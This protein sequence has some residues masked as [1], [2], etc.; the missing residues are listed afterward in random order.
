MLTKCRIFRIMTL[1]QWPTK[2]LPYEILP[3]DPVQNIKKF[4]F[5]IERTKLV[6]K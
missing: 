4:F 1:I 2:G 3:T 5:Y 6:A